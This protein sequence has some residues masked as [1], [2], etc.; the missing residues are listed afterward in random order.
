MYS[1]IFFVIEVFYHT[2][3]AEKSSIDKLLQKYLCF[4]LG[5]GQLSEF[6]LQS[7]IVTEALLPLFWQ[8]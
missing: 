7:S 4:I 3:F 6:M 2:I 5:L 8:Y 1:L